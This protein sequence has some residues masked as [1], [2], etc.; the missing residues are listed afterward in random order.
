MKTKALAPWY[1]SNRM[2]AH[3]VGEELSGCRWVG[4]PFAGGMSELVYIKAPSIVVSDIHRHVINL[5][6]CVKNPETCRWLVQQLEGLPFH[7]DVLAMAQQKCKARLPGSEPDPEAAMW[8][9]VS[10]WMGRSHKS[11]IGDEFN[12]RISVRWNP[13]GGDS[14][15][16][17]RSAI[18]SLVGWRQIMRRCN[19]ATLDCFEFFDRCED[20]DRHGLYCDPP[21]PGPG[22]KYKHRF[23][24]EQHVQMVERLARFEKCRVVC[25]FYDHPLVRR[26]YPEPRWRWIHLEG[27]SQ[28]NGK[29]PEVLITNRERTLFD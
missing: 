3:R 15:T 17:Y 24:E 2:L 25:R 1:G 22:D 13:N 18:R 20:E 27:R 6:L 21:F 12:G 26:L 7:D 8:Y 10:C 29:T 23:T 5:A 16:R 9:F 19:F 28:S 11:G 4:V 14:N